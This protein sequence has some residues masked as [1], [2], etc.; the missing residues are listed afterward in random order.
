MI[1]STHI[2][3]VKLSDEVEER[4]QEVRTLEHTPASQVLQ[5]SIPNIRNY[6]RM[7]KVVEG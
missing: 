7:L 3:T 5:D 6:I 2:V 1:N 4:K